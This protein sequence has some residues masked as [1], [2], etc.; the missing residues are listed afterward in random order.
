MAKKSTPAQTFAR[1]FAVWAC[2]GALQGDRDNAER[3]MDAWLARYGKTR[4]DIPS[5]LAQAG[6]DD[7]AAAPPPP[8]SDP[9]DT[10][11]HPFEN[12]RFNPAS[13]V[14]GIVEKYLTMEW[15]VSVIYSL[16]I[17]F[18]HVYTLFEIA[19]RLV[20]VSEGPYS[21]KSTARKVAR[22]LCTD[23][24]RKLSA[25]PRRSANISIKAPALYC[26]TS[27]I[28]LMRMRG[29]SS[30]G[31]GILDTSETQKFH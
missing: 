1:I 24:T 23:P 7:A 29:G 27:L 17:V 16:W 11:P 10:Q 5:I 9:R 26:S 3:Q 6:L 14:Q 21:G 18:T 31:F 30:C 8:P 12:P 4:S 22:H 13:L 28:T 2:P 19:P 15:Y 20:M 25:P